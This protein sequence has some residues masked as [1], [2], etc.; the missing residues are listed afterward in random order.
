MPV[1]SGVNLGE[2]QEITLAGMSRFSTK[3]FTFIPTGLP[4]APKPGKGANLAEL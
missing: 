4:S 2:E 1:E 3:V